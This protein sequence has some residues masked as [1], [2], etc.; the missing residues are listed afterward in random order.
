MTTVSVFSIIVATVDRYFAI[1]HPHS[2]EKKVDGTITTIAIVICWILGVAVGG[3]P[4][5]VWKTDANDSNKSTC[6]PPEAFD[7]SHIMFLCFSAYF[8]PVLIL[9]LGHLTIFLKIRQQVSISKFEYKLL[10]KS[11]SHLC[12][13]NFALRWSSISATLI[14]RLALITKTKK[15]VEKRCL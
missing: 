8:V 9:I 2:Y 13:Q 10:K 1:C 15:N 7:K 14:R 6:T 5:F 3:L 4:I 12:R 11:Y